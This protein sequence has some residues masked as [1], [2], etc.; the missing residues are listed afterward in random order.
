METAPACWLLPLDAQSHFI[1]RYVC[2]A[3]RWFQQRQED[4]ASWDVV[5]MYYGSN[6]DFS[7]EQCIAVQ[8]LPGAKVNGATA[9]LM[10]EGSS[11]SFRTQHAVKR[12]LLR[13][14]TAALHCILSRHA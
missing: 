2:P 5:A 7:C 4:G 3:H 8:R 11:S 1:I 9:M 13:R 12:I 10:N 6:A 14:S